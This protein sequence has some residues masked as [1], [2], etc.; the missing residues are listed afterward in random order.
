MDGKR[1]VTLTLT[2]ACNLS[3]V[4]CYE[5]NRSTKSMGFDTAKRIIDAEFATNDPE[6]IEFDLFGGEPFLK[7][8]LIKQIDEY[9]VKNYPHRRWMLFATTNGTLVHGEIQSWLRARPYFYCG[10]S[11]DGT[12]EM[13]DANR[14]NSFD[15]IDTKFFKE[16]YPKQGIKMTVSNLSLPNLA[17]GVIF[18]HEMGFDVD[19]NLAYG[20]DW[21]NEDNQKI[22]AEQ[23]FELIKFYIDNPDI[24]P[25]K[26]LSYDISSVAWCSEVSP[27]EV[28]RWCGAGSGMHTYDV[29]GDSYPCQ[30]FMPLS[31]GEIR[32][33]ESKEINFVDMIPCTCLDEKCRNCPFVM[34]C[35]TCYGSNYYGS[36]NIYIKNDD[37]CTLM[38]IIFKACA[39]LKAEQWMRKRLSLSKEQEISLLRSIQLIQTL[40]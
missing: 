36:G 2:D 13:H 40:E 11:L 18:L 7:F 20:I 19:C 14:S 4:Y 23:L 32:A 39:F 27:K 15:N 26:M 12:K 30:F 24:K 28:R 16:L 3:C 8:N 37:Y 35:P 33:K 29:N 10:L 5:H 34:A 9:L 38:K 17:K 31:V 6:T 25:C 1:I 21:S 22:I